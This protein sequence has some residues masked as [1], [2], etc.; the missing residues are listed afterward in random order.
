MS[1][2]GPKKNMVSLYIDDIILLIN[3]PIT[4]NSNEHTKCGYRMQQDPPTQT[5]F[6]LYLFLLHK[7]IKN[8]CMYTQEITNNTSPFNTFFQ[9]L[10]PE[11]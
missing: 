4:P 6:F 10:L 3:I 11:T 8:V 7:N 9:F 2:V 5:K 1:W